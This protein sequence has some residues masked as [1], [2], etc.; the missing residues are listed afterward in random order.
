MGTCSNF[1][2]VHAFDLKSRKWLEPLRDKDER[3]VWNMTLGSDGKIYGGT[4]PG[5]VLF[6]YDP[7]KHGY[8][9]IICNSNEST[10]QEQDRIGLLCEKCV[11]GIIII[12]ATAEGKH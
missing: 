2:Y 10:K 9:M 7:E 5:C 12:P 1:G 6:Q 3:Y 8:S 11:D 4:W